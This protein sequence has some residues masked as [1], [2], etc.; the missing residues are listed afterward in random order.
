MKANKVIKVF[1]IGG[2]I[3]KEY[4]PQI[5]AAAG[6][7]CFVASIIFAVKE[8]PE[9]KEILDEKLESD[10]DMNAVEKAATMASNMKKTIIFGSAG[11]I[12]TTAGWAK[13]VGKLGAGATAIAVA[14]EE[15][16]DLIQASKEVVGEEKTKE[17]LDRKTIIASRPKQGDYSDER[18]DVIHPFIFDTGEVIWM[19]WKEFDRRLEQAMNELVENRT[20][21]MAKFMIIMGSKHPPRLS[22]AWEIPIGFDITTALNYAKDA[23]AIEESECAYNSDVNGYRVQFKHPDEMIYDVEY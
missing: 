6:T 23:L 1:K 12:F 14:K 4:G 11:V 2:K 16:A 5:M 15:T 9:A 20:L 18:Y 8:A 7:V 3:V 21:S 22:I 10:P 17:I 13:I 19:S